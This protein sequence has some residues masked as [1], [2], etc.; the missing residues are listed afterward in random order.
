MTFE[1]LATA[2]RSPKANW[3]IRLIPLLTG[4]ARSAYVAMDGAKAEDYGKV[5]EAIL[6]K[7]EINAEIYRQRFRS[8][9][10]LL[11]ET[12]RELYVRLKDLF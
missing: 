1:R 4:N 3:A 8:S 7:Y 6:I 10:I 12:P 11:D 2:C 5:K 9:E